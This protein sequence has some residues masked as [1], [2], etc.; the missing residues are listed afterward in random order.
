MSIKTAIVSRG[1]QYWTSAAGERARR[2]AA[3]R[4]RKASGAAHIVHLLHDA[5]DPYSHLLI[6][7]LPLLAARY[8]VAFVP[9]LVGAPDDG[10]APEPG[11]LAAWALRDAGLLAGKALG[12]AEPLVAPN[13][14]RVTAA[15]ARFAA[16]FAAATNNDWIDAATAIDRALWS[17][18][19]GL[20]AHPAAD[21][22][23]VAAAKAAGDTMRASLGHYLG[24]VLSYGGENY[25]GI[26]RLHYLEERLADLGLRHADASEGPIYPPP[27]DMAGPV[28][29]RPAGAPRPEL[30][31][32]LSFRSP[33]T[34]IAA[35]RVRA[36]AEAHGA[37]LKLRFVLPMVMRA[38][39][40]PPAKRR[41]ITLDT[42]REARRLGIPFGKIADPVG[43][44][45]ERGYSLLPWAREQG[46]GIEFVIA[47]LRGAF[48]QGIDAGSDA[49]M[50]RIVT[51]A[52]L[53]WKAAR[54][55]I[56]NDDWRAEAEANRAEMI[57]L[58]LWGVP[59]FRTGDVAVWGQDRLWA[60]D[61]ALRGVDGN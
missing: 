30:H 34:W 21:R 18:G 61:A 5:A 45:V 9:H 33:Y 52:G 24:G 8:D 43:R 58:G 46:R 2:R 13:P 47:F 59:S 56:D 37:D 31:Y 22:A 27:P 14:D 38:L 55:V 4:A 10:A 39:P 7:Q 26:D 11:L 35:E 36:V 15:E 51:A 48:A 54:S 32:Y 42:A 12:A 3:E 25:W 49:G 44:P 20:A 50:K 53:D 17:G 29:A 6:Q 40:V 41:Y 60:I 16:L 1:A 19:A 28:A 57:A 23:A